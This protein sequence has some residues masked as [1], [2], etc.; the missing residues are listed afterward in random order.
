MAGILGG[1]LTPG[2]PMGVFY[3]AYFAQ[4]VGFGS[5]STP[6]I[7]PIFVKFGFARRTSLTILPRK[8]SA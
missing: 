3:C 8:F 7:R 6:G 4:C 2:Q 1:T 5:V